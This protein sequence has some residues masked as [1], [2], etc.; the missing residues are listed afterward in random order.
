[1]SHEPA[2]ID[3]AAAEHAGIEQRPMI[4]VR[5]GTGRQEPLALR[6]PLVVVRR[7]SRR[8]VQTHIH[9]DASALDSADVIAT[10]ILSLQEWFG[11][12]AV[13]LSPDVKSIAIWR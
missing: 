1:M 11:S 3:H 8:L 5:R 2:E 10:T 7:R 6:C 13:V 4:C 9:Y 12:A